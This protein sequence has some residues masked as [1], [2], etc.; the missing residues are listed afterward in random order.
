MFHSFSLYIS[1]RDLTNSDR[2]FSI[3]LGGEEEEED[4]AAACGEVSL[5]GIWSSSS[6]VN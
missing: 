4:G 5:K 6:F 3:R 1:Q 2:S